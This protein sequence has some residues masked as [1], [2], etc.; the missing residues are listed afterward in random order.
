MFAAACPVSCCLVVVFAASR[1]PEVS[2]SKFFVLM[3]RAG[4]V[5]F[6]A[7]TEGSRWVYT[8]LNW[9]PTEPTLLRKGLTTTNCQV[10]PLNTPSEQTEATGPKRISFL[11]NTVLDPRLTLM[12]LNSNPKRKQSGWK[13]F[14]VYLFALSSRNVENKFAKTN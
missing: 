9:S 6:S 2:V 3:L 13:G 10:N 14:L 4:G 11:L 7:K 5:P 12:I 1:T 8:I